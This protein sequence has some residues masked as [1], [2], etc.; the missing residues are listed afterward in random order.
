M[1]KYTLGVENLGKMGKQAINKYM[2]FTKC[3]SILF[4]MLNYII[5]NVEIGFPYC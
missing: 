4:N 3:L 1:L 2:T 5:Q